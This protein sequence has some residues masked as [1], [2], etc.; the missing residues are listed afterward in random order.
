M[1]F[2]AFL[3]YFAG[4]DNNSKFGLICDRISRMDRNLCRTVDFSSICSEF[5]AEPRIM[6]N[7][8]YD[9]FGMSGEEIIEQCCEGSLVFME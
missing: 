5:R 9:V 8:F 1:I 4:M 3:A 6:N 7:M 2:L